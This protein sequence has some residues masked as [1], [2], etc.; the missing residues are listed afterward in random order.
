MRDYDCSVLRVDD[1]TGRDDIS[2][3]SRVKAANEA[4]A[5]VYLSMHHNAGLNGRK[6]GGTVILSMKHAAKT[7]QG[8]LAF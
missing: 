4:G 3:Y 8:V 6:G 5:A 7:A 1:T 2:L